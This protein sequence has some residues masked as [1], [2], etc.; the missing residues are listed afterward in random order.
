MNRAG[1]FG[2]DELGHR[3]VGQDDIEALRGFAECRATPLEVNPRGS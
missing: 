2:A 3:L 1:E